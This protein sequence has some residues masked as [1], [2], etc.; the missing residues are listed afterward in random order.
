MWQN[1]KVAKWQ[2]MSSSTSILCHFAEKLTV[3]TII[4]IDSTQNERFIK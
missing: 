1:G 3:D 2:L 4:S